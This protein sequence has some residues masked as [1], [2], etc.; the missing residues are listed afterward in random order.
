MT[1]ETPSWASAASILRHVKY[2]AF[3]K[4]EE[5]LRIGAGKGEPVGETSLPIIK[6][7]HASKGMEIPYIPGS[8]I[9][10]LFRSTAESIAKTASLKPEPCSGLAKNTCMDK[11]VEGE[12]LG[13]KIDKLLRNNETKQALN[14]FWREACLL[15]KI[16][17]SPSYRSRIEFHD[18]YPY[19]TRKQDIT[20]VPVGTK[21]GIAIDRSTGA[22]AKGALYQVTYIEPGS[23]FSF[24]ITAA[25]LPNYALGLLLTIVK[26]L[27]QGLLRIG[28]FK[29]KGFGKVQVTEPEIHIKH[30]SVQSGNETTLQ[31]LDNDDKKV[32]A[33]P[34]ETVDSWLIYRERQYVELVGKL[35][36]TWDSHVGY[37]RSG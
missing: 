9:K 36:A 3:L 24:N 31:P 33:S 23:Y 32:E 18:S 10:G 4:L 11:P 19:D 12:R 8:S 16:F 5:P 25:N 13:A 37:K 17:G 7:I 14:L 35:I 26:L 30:Y 1:E 28:G 15:C 27:D 21:T 6:V 2:K 22:V 34:T 29:S 20:S